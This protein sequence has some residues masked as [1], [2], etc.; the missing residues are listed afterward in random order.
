MARHA[1]IAGAG[2]GGLAAAL[3]LLQ[4]GWTVRVHERTPFLRSEGF[5]VS[6]HENGLRIFDSLG[7]REAVL[8]KSVR[9]HRRI[10]RNAAGEITSDRKNPKDM[11]R[12]S[13]E[14]I[15]A[16]LAGKVASLGGEVVTGSPA[17]AADPAGYLILEN[18]RR[19]KADLVIGADGYNSRIRESVG[20][21]KR[22]I[23]LR[24]GAMRLVIPRTA[25]ER[26]AEPE[27]G[28]TSSENWSGTRRA[29]YG[30][31]AIDQVYMALSCLYGDEDGMAVPT[32]TA[33]WRRSL[34]YLADA[35]DRIDKLT[36]WD[37]VKWVRFQVI[38]LKRW[39]IGRV[40][41]LGDAAHAMPPNLG[42]GGGCAIMN[43]FSLAV[44]LD[45]GADLGASLMR[46][47]ERER[48][49]T[50][51]TQ[52]WSRFYGAVTLWPEHFRS[53]AFSM[54]ERSTWLRS[55]LDRTAR[56]VPTGA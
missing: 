36:D 21:L 18:G 52:R 45:S 3:A 34:P 53:F 26:A 4:R 48:P 10:V 37:H 42:Q 25:E 13:R 2:F 54:T 56:Y 41:I 43:A 32:R 39:S 33:A 5:G 28:T 51:H 16:A 49:V 35:F 27:G 50:E 17:A 47:E 1:E 55:Q 6:F 12:V 44:A 22:R 8:A 14:N 38:K 20:L 46:W 30:A 23:M 7:V 31:C 29:I 40:A 19:L 9:V 15:V 11:H 24:D